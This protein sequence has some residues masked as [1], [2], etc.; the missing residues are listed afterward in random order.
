MNP[1]ENRNSQFVPIVVRS[2]ATD[3]GI[4]FVAPIEPFSA[5]AACR[6]A[7]AS[8]HAKNE[9]NRPAPKQNRNKRLYCHASPGLFYHFS[10]LGGGFYV[11]SIEFE[12][13]PGGED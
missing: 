11:L 9:H 12:K 5:R 2:R 4:S 3:S 8:K 6:P 1:T 13:V 7:A 10:Q